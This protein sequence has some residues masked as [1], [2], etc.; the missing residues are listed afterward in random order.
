MCSKAKLKGLPPKAAPPPKL[1]AADVVK[2][3]VAELAVPPGGAAPPTAG[4]GVQLK[5]KG[6]LVLGALA[7]EIPLPRGDGMAPLL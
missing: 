5:A 3:K 1:E 4:G 2:L 6:A 7:L